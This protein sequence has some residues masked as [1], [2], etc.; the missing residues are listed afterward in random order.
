LSRKWGNFGSR[1]E[2]CINASEIKWINWYYEAKKVL[3]K[4]DICGKSR[5]TRTNNNQDRLCEKHLTYKQKSMLAA[6][7]CIRLFDKN[8]QSIF[9]VKSFLNFIDEKL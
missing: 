7:T 9:M 5:M 6:Q 1:I 8:R 2:S 3:Q 4:S